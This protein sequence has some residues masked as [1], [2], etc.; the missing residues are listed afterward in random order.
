MGSPRSYEATGATYRLCRAT[1]DDADTIIDLIDSAADWLRTKDTDQWRRPWPNREERDRRVR[2]GLREHRTWIA[3]DGEVAAATITL[4][5]EADPALWNER[6]RRQR[7]VYVHRLVIDRSRAGEGLGAALL[8]WA[9]WLTQSTYGAGWTRL[10]VWRSNH[11]L[12]LYYRNQGFQLVRYKSPQSHY[13]C[14][15]LFEKTTERAIVPGILS[16]ATATRARAH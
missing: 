14:G 6:E 5:R 7:A 15:A 9:A 4:D 10:D 13:P 11:A 2:A 12:H 8:E 16:D 3:R 1:V